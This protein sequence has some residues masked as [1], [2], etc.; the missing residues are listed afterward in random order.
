VTVGADALARLE[1]RVGAGGIE[2]LD[3]GEVDPHAGDALS[4][5]RVNGVA[6]K[7]RRSVIGVA[8]QED[9]DDVVAPDDGDREAMAI[10]VHRDAVTPHVRVGCEL[11]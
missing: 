10:D 4:G 3:A 11:P 1:Q 7:S 9:H 2:L 8:V 5:E 6:Q